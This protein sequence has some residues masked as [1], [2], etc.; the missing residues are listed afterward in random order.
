MFAT[1]QAPP[2]TV[3]PALAR[4]L[5]GSFAKELCRSVRA[6]LI[7]HGMSPTGFGRVAVGDPT[8]VSRRLR[9]G[10]R[11]K[12]STA[13]RTRRFVGEQPFRPVL[14]CEVK[15]FLAVTGVKGWKA[16]D[17][18]LNQ[19]AFIERLF[20]GASPWLMTIDRF[21]RWMHAQLKPAERDAVIVAVA[22]E[23][24]KE[25]ARQAD[26]ENPEREEESE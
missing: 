21:R 15:A 17:W 26:G 1:M 14:L 13:D 4:L 16:G 10:K 5:H 23:L 3:D 20:A 12:L 8:F 11:V 19:R 7:R 2:R 18:A 22:G 24:A 25:P 9:K 6:Y